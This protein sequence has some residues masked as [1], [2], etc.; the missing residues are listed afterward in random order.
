MLL[1]NIKSK[2]VE[3]FIELYGFSKLLSDNLGLVT[4]ATFFLDHHELLAKQVFQLS[5]C[6]STPS[7]EELIVAANEMIGEYLNT[8]GKID[9]NTQSYVIFCLLSLTSY[10]AITA[11]LGLTAET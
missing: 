6:F 9:V 2:A 4:V 3:A 7:V 1:R 8:F 10:Y 11:D 5:Q